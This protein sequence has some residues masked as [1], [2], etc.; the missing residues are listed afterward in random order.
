MNTREE[1]EKKK[2]ATHKKKNKKKTGCSVVANDIGVY[3]ICIGERKKERKKEGK[4]CIQVKVHDFLQVIY[5]R[6]V[7]T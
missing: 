4:L 5:K 3:C 2:K 1:E 6:R 7:T